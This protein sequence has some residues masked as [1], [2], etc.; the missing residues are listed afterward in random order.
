M[1]Y[2]A[3]N[4]AWA[5]CADFVEAQFSGD[6]ITLE[7]F[8]KTMRKVEE[9]KFLSGYMVK[10]CIRNRMGWLDISLWYGLERYIDIRLLMSLVFLRAD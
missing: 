9:E 10:K 4:K 3:E 8:L 6:K 1:D 7:V 2:V 5:E